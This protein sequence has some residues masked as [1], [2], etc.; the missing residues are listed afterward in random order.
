VQED[1]QADGE[2][3]KAEIRPRGFGSRSDQ[4]ISEA[5]SSDLL[6]RDRMIPSGKTPFQESNDDPNSK[7]QPVRNQAPAD[8]RAGSKSRRSRSGRSG[9][10]KSKALEFRLRTVVFISVISSIVSGALFFALGRHFGRSAAQT[11]ELE[12]ISVTNDKPTEF[13]LRE[14]ETA[15]VNLQNGMFP[16]AKN[17][18]SNLLDQRAPISSLAV[19]VG[20]AALLDEDIPLAERCVKLSIERNESVSDALMLQA[21]IEAKLATNPQHK[22]MGNPR[23]RIESLLQQSIAADASNAR[24]FFELATLRRF[25]KRNEEALELLESASNRLGQSDSIMSVNLAKELVKLEQLPDSELAQSAPTGSDVQSLLC[26]AYVAARLGDPNKAAELVAQAR[27]V[28]P[29]KTFNQL[30]KDPAF[31]P[32]R[33]EPALEKFFPKQK[34]N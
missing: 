11:V 26:A 34:T 10:S 13:Q 19:I 1:E 31:V 6:E 21:I 28:T 30:L 22:A 32:W 18:L 12:K 7:S 15:L 27:S 9:K 5:A 23:I 2:Q 14:F 24:P 8:E 20:N 25:E 33:K 4:E 3:R 17:A 29:L 16:E